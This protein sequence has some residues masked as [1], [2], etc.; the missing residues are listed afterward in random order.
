MEITRRNTLKGG[1]VLL[2]GTPLL[3]SFGATKANVNE[4]HPEPKV[5]I[6]GSS[7]YSGVNLMMYNNGFELDLDSQESIGINGNSPDEFLPYLARLFNYSRLDKDIQ[8][9]VEYLV[10][11]VNH[12]P[13]ITFTRAK[14]SLEN[15]VYQ[16][17][18][19]YNLLDEG[20]EGYVAQINPVVVIIRA[21]GSGIWFI[22]KA[23]ATGTLACLVDTLARGYFPILEAKLIDFWEYEI[24][25]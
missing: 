5:F 3:G 1:T 9:P 6:N 16:D 7:Q 22:F 21:I 8:D 14:E 20:F 2:A 15:V 13:N 11:E 4:H 25:A 23:L 12:Y 24:S 17:M 19:I 10:S 18:P